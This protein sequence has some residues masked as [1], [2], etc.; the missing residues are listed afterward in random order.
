VSQ[1]PE[2]ADETFS[3]L[4]IYSRR[5]HRG[6][7]QKPQQCC[8]GNG[9]FFGSIRLSQRVIDE[10]NLPAKAPV[11]FEHEVEVENTV[12]LANIHR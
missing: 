5:N 11:A 8:R 9:K 1:T 10:L 12:V 3:R 2:P 6:D 7:E 4:A